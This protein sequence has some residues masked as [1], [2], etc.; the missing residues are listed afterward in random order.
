MKTKKRN[1]YHTKNTKCFVHWY[2]S[3]LLL[4]LITAK[5]VKNVLQFRSNYDVYLNHMAFRGGGWVES[6]HTMSQIIPYLYLIYKKNILHSYFTI[7]VSNLVN[8]ISYSYFLSTIII[9]LSKRLASTLAHTMHKHSNQTNYS[10]S[11]QI[12]FFVS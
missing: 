12:L 7:N 10:I 9:F 8:V 6:K 5:I 3:K 1:Q 2:S 11:Y 4:K